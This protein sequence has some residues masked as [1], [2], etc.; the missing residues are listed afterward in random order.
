MSDG[1]NIIQGFIFGI[2][3]LIYM[4]IIFSI[5]LFA[6]RKNLKIAP[7]LLIAAIVNII[8]LLSRY[9]MIF[10]QNFDMEFK[11]IA[12]VYGI[13]GAISMVS[14][15]LFLGSI[16]NYFIGIKAQEVDILKDEL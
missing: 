14:I 8:A 11:N 2:L 1:L 15:I 13:I 12:L 6:Y 9:T 16:L 5:V 7:I 3:D 10:S 4:G